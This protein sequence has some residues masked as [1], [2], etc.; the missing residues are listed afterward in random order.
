MPL[1][2]RQEIQAVLLLPEFGHHVLESALPRRQPKQCFPKFLALVVVNDGRE[3]TLI[4]RS[5]AFR[6]EGQDDLVAIAVRVNAVQVFHQPTGAPGFKTA[7]MTVGKNRRKGH[8]AAVPHHDLDGR[9]QVKLCSIDMI[10]RVHLG[11][12][13]AAGVPLEL[14]QRVTGHR[15][16]TARL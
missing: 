1:W 7:Q 3:F 2:K 11:Q 6:D 13:L 16:K 9:I 14:V 10:N 8:K 5:S 4:G 15:A 12:A